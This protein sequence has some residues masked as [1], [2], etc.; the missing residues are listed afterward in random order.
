MR[1][2]IWF[3]NLTILVRFR[4]MIVWPRPLHAKSWRFFRDNSLNNP[5]SKP[6]KHDPFRKCSSKWLKI[7]TN[8]H[9]WYIEKS[10]VGI[11]NVSFP[12]FGTQCP[13]KWKIVFFTS[14]MVRTIKM[15]TL[16]FFSHMA[17]D[18]RYTSFF[19]IGN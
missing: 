10:G 5:K 9:H 19:V 11:L 12:L 2:L 4:F 18:Y 7:D 16:F 8:H 17:G 15:P 14:E 6:K 1:T 13:I 3:Q